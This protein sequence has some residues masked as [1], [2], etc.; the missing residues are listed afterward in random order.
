MKSK[1]RFGVLL[2]VAV[3]IA[4]PLGST[5]AQGDICSMWTSAG[6]TADD[7]A[8]I[9]S[10]MTPENMGKLGSFVADYSMALKLTGSGTNDVDLN[11]KGGGPISFDPASTNDQ[12]AMM[13]SFKL[14]QTV[15]VSGTASGKAEEHS[16]EVRI[17]DGKVYFKTPDAPSNDKWLWQSLSS[18]M[19]SSMSSNPM[20]GMMGSSNPAAGMAA[21]PEMMAAIQKLTAVPGFIKISSAASGDEK[22]ITFAFD[23]GALASAPNLA[24]ILKDIVKASTPGGSTMDEATLDQQVQQYVSMGTVFLKNAKLNVTEYFG[25][26]KLFHG[27]DMHIDYKLDASMAAAMMN[28]TSKEDLVATFDLKFHLSKIGEAVTVEA[29]ADATE[30]K[31]DGMSSGSGSM[32][33]TPEAEATEAQ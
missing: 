4:L 32:E 13:A 21:S 11:V 1:I 18:L 12:A 29:P 28:S 9:T 22:A 33:T 14:Q 24:E 8:L 26:D 16:I 27:I 31:A 20:M 6:L 5:R 17:V 25:S 3:L 7:C 19:S 10:A 2:M 23:F 30:F 15:T